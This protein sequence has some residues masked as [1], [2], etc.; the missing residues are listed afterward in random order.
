MICDNISII[1]KTNRIESDI[2]EEQSIVGRC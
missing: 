2:K 1:K